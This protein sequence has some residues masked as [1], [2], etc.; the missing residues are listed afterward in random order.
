MPAGGVPAGAVA[1]VC[2]LICGVPDGAAAAVCWAA[3]VTDGVEGM[4]LC[5]EL[6]V[7]LCVQPAI[8]IPAM[9]SAD[10]I[11]IRMLLFFMKYTTWDYPGRFRF[12]RRPFSCW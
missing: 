2:P 10:P 3:A 12:F 1:F 7:E 9:R 11:S 4:E 5:D 6:L 8:R